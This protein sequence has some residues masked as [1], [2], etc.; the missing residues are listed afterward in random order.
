[1]YAASQGIVNKRGSYLNED[2]YFAGWSY[3]FQTKYQEL[4]STATP[5]VKDVDSPDF[6]SYVYKYNFANSDTKNCLY[7]EEIS[8]S[9][10][11]R[12]ITKTSQ[13]SIDDSPSSTTAGLTKIVSV[14][15][16]NNDVP[17]ELKQNYFIPYISRYSGGFA[18]ID[19]MKIPRPCAF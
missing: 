16:E 15:N 2:Y 1:M 4:S 7:E 12:R 5:T 3:G 19:T 13:S 18:L 11:R 6:D 8:N 17:K 10:V 14:W 9:D